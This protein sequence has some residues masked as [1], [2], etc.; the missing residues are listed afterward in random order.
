[1]ELWNSSYTV[2]FHGQSSGVNSS[3]VV[4]RMGIA[5]HLD[6]HIWEVR[7]SINVDRGNDTANRFLD[8]G[9]PYRLCRKY[10][11][12]FFGSRRGKSARPGK[13][14]R[15]G[16]KPDMTP[17][18]TQD[19]QLSTCNIHLNSIHQ[20]LYQLRLAAASAAAR[21]SSS[22]RTCSRFSRFSCICRSRST[23][24]RSMISIARCIP[25]FSRERRYWQ[26]S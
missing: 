26:N 2:D 12:A 22:F 23:L 13:F 16:S 17:Q 4:A 21:S 8:F 11:D 9:I 7:S 5:Q 25:T 6:L 18:P 3:V 24:R 14:R 1:M 20:N 10:L 15:D 19:G